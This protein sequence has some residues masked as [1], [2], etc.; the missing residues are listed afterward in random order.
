MACNIL[1]HRTGSFELCEVVDDRYLAHGN[2][3]DVISGA[4]LNDATLEGSSG[5][6]LAG[7]DY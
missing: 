3:L 6:R 4:V 2:E 7:G 5:E 1:G